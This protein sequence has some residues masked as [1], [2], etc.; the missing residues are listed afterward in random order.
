MQ[1]ANVA[2][3]CFLGDNDLLLQEDVK[4]LSNCTVYKQG[5]FLFFHLKRKHNVPEHPYNLSTNNLAA[6][7]AC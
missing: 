1:F 7:S 6:M 2:V 5:L 3:F 4:Q